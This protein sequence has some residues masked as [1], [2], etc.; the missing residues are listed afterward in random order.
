MTLARIEAAFARARTEARA[1][2]VSYVM[3]GDPDLETSFQHVEALAASGSDIIEL[4]APFTDPMADGVAI[5]KAGLRALASGTTLLDV[6]ALARRFRQVN[7]TTPLI[8]MGYANP[9][10][11]MGY[12]AF[13]AAAAEA[14]LDGVITVDLPPEEDAPL[15]EPLAAHGIAVIRLATP[16]SDAARLASIADGSSGF[17]YFVAVTGVTGAGSA[18]PAAIAPRIAAAKAATGLPV[19]VGFGVKTGDQAAQMA[20]IADGVVV[21]SAYVELIRNAVEAAQPDRAKG[22]LSNLSKALAAAIAK[23]RKV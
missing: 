3:A 19:C 6:L 20:E 17:V 9:V 8:L 2:L 5:Q 21:G 23:T 12:D 13:A 22:E 14:G 7:A 15:R 18:D 1:V 10:H 4:G 11:A 16:T